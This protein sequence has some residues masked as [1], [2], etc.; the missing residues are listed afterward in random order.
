MTTAALPALEPGWCPGVT[1][2]EYH[3]WDLCSNSALTDL[4][5]SPAYAR[6][7]R[8]VRREPSPAMKFGDAAHVAILQPDLFAARFVVL[9]VCQGK[10]KSGAACDNPAKVEV[11]GGQFCGVHAPKGAAMPEGRTILTA[12]E[13]NHVQR[14]RD[15]VMRHP[16]ARAALEADGG[17]NETPGLFVDPATGLLCKFKPDRVVPALGLVIDVKA[18]AYAAPDR[19]PRFLLNGGGHRQAAFYT[20]GCTACGTGVDNFLFVAAEPDEP[21]EV[22]VYDLK[23]ETIEAGRRQVSELRA[24]Y[25]ECVSSGKWPGYSEDVVPI[26][27]EAWALRRIEDQD[28]PNNEGDNDHA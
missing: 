14:V 18:T 24:R 11:D 17:F 4:L 3:A 22:A 21:N 9:G 1:D 27:L 19:F 5:R 2:A 12:T 13:Y 6:L 20:E 23:P 28:N 25:A 8:L 15:A 10:L 16:M 7:S 26:G